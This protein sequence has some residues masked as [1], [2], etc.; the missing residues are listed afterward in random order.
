MFNQRS[1][2]GFTL[3]EII[4]SIGVFA[5]LSIIISG[6]YLNTSNLQRTTANFQLLQND[7]RYILD[8]IAK[9]FRARELDYTQIDESINTAIYFKPDQ[10]GKEVS[11]I[12]DE[13]TQDLMYWE[14]SL[15]APLNAGNVEVINLKFLVYPAEYDPTIFDNDYTPILNQPRLTIL[16]SLRNRDLDPRY[17]QELTLQTTISSKVYL[18]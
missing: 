4:L 13:D 11:L 10:T 18:R 5:V 12:Y 9:E 15:S 6:I 17:Q 2:S 3:I 7:G 1:Q 14:D 16:L 8:K